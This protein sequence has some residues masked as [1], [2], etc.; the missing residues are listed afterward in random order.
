MTDGKDKTNTD[1]D[2]DIISNNTWVNSIKEL[3]H[4]L[5]NQEYIPQN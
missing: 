3:V 2:M 1:S 5:I 4:L